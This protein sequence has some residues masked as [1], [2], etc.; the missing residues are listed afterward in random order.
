MAALLSSSG[1]ASAHEPPPITRNDYALELFQGP[2]L[3]PGRITGLR[4]RPTATAQSLEGV[5]NNAAA[6]AVREPHSLDHFEWEPTGG[7]RVLR[8]RMAE[9][10][11]TTAGRRGSSSR[12]SVTKRL[13]SRARSTVETTDRFLYLQRRPLGTDRQLRR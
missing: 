5:Y 10:T 11:S 13:G 3:A 8:V 4:G 2:L 7:D 1:S 6:P 9:P 12:S